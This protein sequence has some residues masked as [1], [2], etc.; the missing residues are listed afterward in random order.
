VQD[1]KSNPVEHEDKKDGQTKA[2]T[3]EDLTL[4]VSIDPES[5]P[6]QDDEQEGH[7]IDLR[8]EE[9]NVRSEG[10]RQLLAR[11][12]PCTETKQLETKRPLELS[13]PIG[14]GSWGW[15]GRDPQ[16]FGMGRSWGLNNYYYIL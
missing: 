3:D 10:K 6:G 7:S 5:D 15:R 8:C 2:K 14:I 11:I 13:Q 9:V 12:R 4:A 16:D 1:T